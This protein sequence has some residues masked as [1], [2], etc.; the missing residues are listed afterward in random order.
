M[1]VILQEKV[2]IKEDFLFDSDKELLDILLK[3]RTS[4]K[5]IIW[6][7]DDYKVCGDNFSANDYITT[8][9]ITGKNGNVIKPR[10]EKSKKEQTVRIREKAEVFT[11]SWICNAQN[12]LVDNVWFD[13]NNIFNKE[14]EKGWETNN[15]K[16]L[17][18]KGKTWQDYILSTRLEITCGE[19]PY[20]TSRYDTVTGE[21]IEP[22]DR[23]GLLD[24][25]LRIISENVENKDK[26]VNWAKKAVQNIYGY[27]WQGDNVLLARENILYAVI[28]YYEF[29][30]NDTL[31]ILI[32]KEFAEIISWNIWQ[33]DGLK[34][35]IPNSCVDEIKPQSAQLLLF[36]IE[37]TK[38][39]PE[40]LVIEEVKKWEN[41]CTGCKTNNP[42]K[43][44]G[45]YC[46]VMDW[47]EN[48]KIRFVDLVYGVNKN[49]R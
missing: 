41:Q 25:K 48:K 5:N 28:E 16:I 22:Q 30:Y 3:D 34:F 4:N 43:H 12:N 44:T 20:L 1:S 21:Y 33:M 7:I 17:F 31:S 40:Q 27:D 29:A 24:R 36:N 6:A 39:K 15:N 26:W 8:E 32:L 45:K 49:D 10:T 2:D 47:A 13:S 14:T 42:L 19:A 18:P 9:S 46:Y 35:V 38:T 11:P 23:I 37:S